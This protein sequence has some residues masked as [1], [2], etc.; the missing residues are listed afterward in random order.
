[1]NVGLI[2]VGRC[3]L[4]I[5]LNLEQKGFKVIASSNDEQYIQ[6]LKNAHLLHLLE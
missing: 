1:M 6:N 3:G 4:P 2:G 5:A